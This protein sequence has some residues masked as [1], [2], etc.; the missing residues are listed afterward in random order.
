M[1]DAQDL[2]NAQNE[3]QR[4]RRE[5]D[6]VEDLG[7]LFAVNGNSPMGQPARAAAGDR[8]N[9]VRWAAIRHGMLS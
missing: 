2:A 5:M 1:P 7:D 4:N 3:E 9:C 8:R 6:Y